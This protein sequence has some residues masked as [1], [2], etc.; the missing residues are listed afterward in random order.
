MKS[1]FESA[2]CSECTFPPNHLISQIPFKDKRIIRYS[3][4]L[5]SNELMIMDFFRKLF[6]LIL[7]S[8]EGNAVDEQQV[9]LLDTGDDEETES[10]VSF[11]PDGYG[12]LVFNVFSID[13]WE[14]IDD[15]TQLTET[16]KFEIIKGLAE[17]GE[18][19][20]WTID[21]REFPNDIE[22]Y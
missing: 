7:Y 20:T 11:Y 9:Y 17:T 16:D 13:Q 3:V 4:K 1:G 10:V 12:N 22:D 14:M 6:E 21:P 8:R 5:Y 2:A 19:E 18:V 15:I